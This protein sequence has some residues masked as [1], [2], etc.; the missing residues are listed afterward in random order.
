MISRKRKIKAAD[1]FCGCGGAT[2]GFELKA[3]QLG[4]DHVSLAVNH[5]DI[6]I[7]TMTAN[8]PKVKAVRADMMTLLPSDVLGGQLD[9]FWASPSCT[10][11]SRAKGGRPRENQLRSQPE[12]LYP[13]IDYGRPKFIVIENVPE[14]V[15]W[16]PLNAKNMPIKKM[17]GKF[18]IHFIEGIKLRGY[19]VDWQVVCCADYGDATTRKR[20]FIKAV[21]HGCGKIEWPH[22]THAENPE[23]DLFGTKLK[24]WRAIRECLDFDDIGKSV[25]NRKKPL[26]EKTM[27]QIAD[28]MR[29]YCGIDLQPFLVKMY[30]T[31]KSNSIDKPIS[32]ITVGG[33]HYALC[34]PFLVKSNNNQTVE[35]VDGPVS[36]IVA[37]TVHHAL[38]TPFIVG[39]T[40]NAKTTELCKP[41]GT[42]TTK[43]H[44]SVVSAFVVDHFNGGKA[45]RTDRPLGTQTTHARYSLV[46]PMVLG[47]QGGAECRLIDCPAPTIATSGA[48]RMITPI[49]IDMSHP[50]ESSSGRVSSADSPVKTITTRNNTAAVFPMLEDGRIIDIYIRMLKPSELAAAHSFPADYVLT[51]N[52]GQQIKQIGNS[53]PVMTAAAMCESALKQLA[54][55]RAA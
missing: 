23:P 11:H 53:V 12:L 19:D 15:E 44:Y 42:C 20:L 48:I 39:H 3:K 5:W 28:G 43:D 18:F 14:F 33:E 6:A 38:C 24:K 8:H 51:G 2:T 40:R 49:I 54:Y 30:G 52:R 32:T 55:G 4:L 29:K 50:G 7:N 36:T 45:E 47:Q 25:F 35:S 31:G 1:A 27:R 34:R 41:I 10:H 26:A 46:T 17:K 22:P 13:W 21:R 16:G 37:G 9:F